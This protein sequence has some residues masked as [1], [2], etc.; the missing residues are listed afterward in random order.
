MPDESQM[1]FWKQLHWGNL[2]RKHSLSFT[3]DACSLHHLLW[4]QEQNRVGL[5]LFLVFP[6][7]SV[8]VHASQ[9]HR[10]CP[11]SIHYLPI[12]VFNYN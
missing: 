8:C 12:N 5:I 1:P 7:W 10:H 3:P 11:H 9:L 2:L 6:S 4:A